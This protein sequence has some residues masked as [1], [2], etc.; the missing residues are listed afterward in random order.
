MKNTH[1]SNMSHMGMT[2]M[3]EEDR[4][5]MAARKIGPFSFDIDDD[6]DTEVLTN[7]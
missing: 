7:E 6:I 4:A 3:N 5:K 2:G 1:G